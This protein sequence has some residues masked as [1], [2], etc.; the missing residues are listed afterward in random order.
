MNTAVL[1]LSFLAGVAIFFSPCGIALLPAYISHLLAQGDEQRSMNARWRQGLQIGLVVSLGI[2]TVFLVTGALVSLLGN[3]I[4]PY[5][6]WIAGVT[7]FILVILGVFMLA[8]KMPTFE[9]P[10]SF[11]TERKGFL[12]FFLYGVGYALGG[13]SCTLPAFLLVVFTS[14]G[15]KSFMGG[16]VNFLFF[17]FGTVL[18]MV[19][20]TVLTAVSKQLVIRWLNKSKKLIFRF[21][22]VVIIGAGIYLVY[23]QIRAFDPFG[24]WS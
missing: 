12:R 24:F 10:H 19:A 1:S 6:P 11:T 21:S 2:M 8:G 23:F 17:T 16:L 22:A 3:V 4:A 13:I 7:G 20:V 15:S 5:A 9:I 18:L 14:L